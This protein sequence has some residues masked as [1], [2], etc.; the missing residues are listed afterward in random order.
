M[1]GSKRWGQRNSPRPSLLQA[2]HATSRAAIAASVASEGKAASAVNAENAA[3]GAAHAAS[4]ATSRRRSKPQQNL[5]SRASRVVA[6]HAHK[7]NRASLGLRAHH[8]QHPYRNQQKNPCWK[9]RLPHLPPNK[10][11]RAAHAR[12]VAAAVAVEVNASANA[13]KSPYRAE[14]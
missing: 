1:A 8:V 6:N 5:K 14:R 4:V 7:V 2:R 11:K 13:A 12:A 3:K 9:L 10:P